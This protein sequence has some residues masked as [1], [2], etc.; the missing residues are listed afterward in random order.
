MIKYK[1]G[2]PKNLEK[3]LEKTPVLEIFLNK[4]AGLTLGTTAQVFSC[5]FR[6]IYKKTFS[7]N[8]SGYHTNI[9]VLIR[10][11]T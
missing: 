6:E 9:V 3:V 7:Q 4:T 11:G 8:T 1:V 10:F 2:V 5:Q